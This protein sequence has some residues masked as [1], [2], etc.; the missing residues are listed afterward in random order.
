MAAQPKNKITRV[1]RGKRRHGNT[2]KLAK[3]STTGLV[4]LYKRGYFEKVMKLV[5]LKTETSKGTKAEAT[6]KTVKT[7]EAA[8]ATIAP[9]T[10]S[11]VSP[12]AQTAKP[13]LAKQA[14]SVK[15]IARTQHKGV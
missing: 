3:E 10:A 4:P 5:G 15:K 13:N 6:P 9:A 1:E 12:I 8:R 14:N 2:P 11:G 7:T